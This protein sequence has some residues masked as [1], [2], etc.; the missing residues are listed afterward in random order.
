MIIT[1]STIIVTRCNIDDDNN[2]DNNDGQTY[3]KQ[4][5]YQS[6]VADVISLAWWEGFEEDYFEE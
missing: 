4:G 2:S 3:N 1:V 5:R 6:A